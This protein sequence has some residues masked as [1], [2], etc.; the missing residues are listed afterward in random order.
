M[1][2]VG[3]RAR[4]VLDAK[5]LT[6]EQ[7]IDF[8][9]LPLLEAKETKFFPSRKVTGKKVEQIIDRRD[10]AALGT[11]WFAVDVL[12]RLRGDYAPKKLGLDPDEGGPVNIYL[13]GIAGHNVPGSMISREGRCACGNSADPLY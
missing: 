2:A 7:I 11:R 6:L 9:L 13:G 12:F 10:V 3:D 1:K 8:Y 4:E 5:G